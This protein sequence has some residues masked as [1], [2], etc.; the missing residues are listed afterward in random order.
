[1]FVLIVG[2]TGTA[3]RGKPRNWLGQ[4]K[5]EYLA[6]LLRQVALAWHQMNF[7]SGSRVTATLQRSGD[8]RQSRSDGV[9]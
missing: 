2:T 3:V 9:Q 7:R 4:G 6:C 5:P 1:M 8:L